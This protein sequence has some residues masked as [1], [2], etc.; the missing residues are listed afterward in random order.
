MIWLNEYP[1][2]TV[3]HGCLLLL[4]WP[5]P[6]CEG[7]YV[8]MTMLRRACPSDVSGLA[9]ERSRDRSQHKT[10]RP[11][12]R[13]R[14]ET[15]HFTWKPLPAFSDSPV[16]TQPGPQKAREA[17]GHIIYW[18]SD[19]M[20][21]DHVRSREVVVSGCSKRSVSGARCSL[22]TAGRQGKTP[23]PGSPTCSPCIPTFH[24]TLDPSPT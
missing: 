10:K 19:A 21:G 13:G 24:Y 20:S 4:A 15:P 14:G 23:V 12:K 18:N 17:V 5:C 11:I 22:K 8:T 1:I 3:C 16:H 9:Q 2:T 7:S 6:R